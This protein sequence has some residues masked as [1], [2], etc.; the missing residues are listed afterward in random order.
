MRAAPLFV[1]AGRRLMEVENETAALQ[2]VFAPVD[3]D[4][5]Q[6]GLER[7]AFAKL[8]QAL[9]GPQ[10]TL[11]GRA[12]GLPRVSQEAVGDPRNLLLIL[13]DE[14]LEEIGL[15]APDLLDQETLVDRNRCLA[16]NHGKSGHS[17]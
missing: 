4:P 8:T 9:I 5:R 7:R 15:S 16:G 3:A 17:E 12:I 13:P 1:L 6:P 2:P 11:L 14:V 10:E